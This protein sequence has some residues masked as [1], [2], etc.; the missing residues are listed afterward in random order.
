MQDYLLRVADG[1]EQITLLIHTGNTG[2]AMENLSL[3]IEGL[4]YVRTHMETAEMLLKL[5]YATLCIEKGV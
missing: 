1:C 4:S 2:E 3:I 5:D